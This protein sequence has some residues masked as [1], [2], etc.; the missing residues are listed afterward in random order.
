MVAVFRN[1]DFV[2]P[3]QM[4]EVYTKGRHSILVTCKTCKFLLCFWL[5]ALSPLCIPQKKQVLLPPVTAI[6]VFESKWKTKGRIRRRH[7]NLCKRIFLQTLSIE[8]PN[9]GRDKK[10]KKKKVEARD[11]KNNSKQQQFL[12]S[13]ADCIVVEDEG[14]KYLTSLYSKAFN[15]NA[16]CSQSLRIANNWWAVVATIYW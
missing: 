4:G 7:W 10:T 6:G 5:S 11:G 12:R 8:F 14:M 13:I 2:D 15:P 16:P 1:N 3:L 9:K